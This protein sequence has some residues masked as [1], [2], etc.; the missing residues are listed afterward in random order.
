VARKR[1]RPPRRIITAVAERGADVQSRGVLTALRAAA[2]VIIVTGLNDV[3]AGAVPSY[4]PFYL[5][6]AA[7]AL[8]VWLDGVILGAFTAAVAVGFYALLFV[9]RAAMPKALLLPAVEAVATVIAVGV[10][11]GMVRARRR[12]IVDFFPAPLPLL[13]PPSVAADNTEVLSALADLRSELKGELRNELRAAVSELSSTDD[14]RLRLSRELA[15]EKARLAALRGEASASVAELE[16]ARQTAARAE[17]AAVQADAAAREA[18]AA[19]R[20]ENDALRT[21]IGR[22]HGAVEASH[23]ELSARVTDITALSAAADELRRAGEIDR[24]RA[25]GERNLRTTAVQRMSELERMLTAERAARAQAEQASAYEQALREQLEQDVATQESH[26][27]TL[28]ARIEELEQSLAEVTT[29]TGD[30][31]RELHD[32]EQTLRD[33]ESELERLLAS[34]EAAHAE[35]A[36]AA[37]ALHL[38]IAELEQALAQS[39]DAHAAD[40]KAFDQK[41]STI[42]AHLAEDHEADLGKA[43]EEREAARAE[44]RSLALRVDKMQKKLDEDHD[45]AT[46][47]LGDSR[48]GAEREME[49]LRARI[50]ELEGKTVPPPAPLR[51][52]VLIAHPDAELRTNARSSLERAGYD[53]LSAADGLEALR[54]AIAQ[55][56]DVVIAD[57]VMPKMNGREL[58][59]LLKSQEKTAHIRVILLTRPTDDLPKGDLLPDEVLRKPVPLET[60]KTALAAVLA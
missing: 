35:T 12:N 4:E 8:V 54:I 29:A 51:K 19:A 18:A 17:A 13:A 45:T 22:L 25:D 43:V 40:T 15:D 6:L 33:R 34:S 53:V 44:S 20:A 57:A 38:R 32:R 23:A 42:V 2:I 7:I 10:I 48:T 11:R 41:L 36:S 30:Q 14:E 24:A 60:L 52:R 55:R 37:T 39:Q 27:A 58:C 56:P 50:A 59:Q 47:L 31:E 16:T 26:A 46:R 49:R 3:I 9:P 1:H 21:E 5:Y 28:R